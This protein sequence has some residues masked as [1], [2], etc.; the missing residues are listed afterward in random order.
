MNKEF[1][2]NFIYLLACAINEVKPDF[3]RVKDIDLKELL[4]QSKRHS[5]AAM[6][7]YALEDAGFQK[8]QISEFIEERDK[9]IR[10]N[11]LYKNELNEICKGLTEN[12]I[13]H[14]PL[15][16]ALIMDLYPKIGMRQMADLD[17]Y[18]D[19]TYAEK[20][21][22]IMVDRGYTAIDVTNRMHDIYQKQPFFDVEM[23]KKLI[24]AFSPAVVDSYYSNVKDRLIES[25]ENEFLYKFS[26]E[27]YYIFMICHAARHY[28]Y[29]GTGLRTF[30]DIYHFKRVNAGRLDLEYIYNECKNINLIDFE[31]AAN[32]LGNLIFSGESYALNKSQ[33][34]MLDFIVA[35]GSYGYYTNT[36]IGKMHDLDPENGDIKKLKG[37]YL[38]SRIFP[39]YQYLQ[40][41]Y[42]V[43][44]NRKYLLPFVWAYRLIYKTLTNWKVANKELQALKKIK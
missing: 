7:A 5:V 44:R 42:P 27:D 28:Y 4:Y 10:K 25:E 33:E 1:R 35:S 15:K 20:V 26:L 24:S 11:I 31:N 13:W 34:I 19:K 6:V 38:I 12:K 16:G 36:I 43:I 40:A 39:S 41:Y 3:E 32:K 9:S 18:F 8:E 37:K 17:I 29:G 23:H 2:D 14:M 21:T 30:L 22:E